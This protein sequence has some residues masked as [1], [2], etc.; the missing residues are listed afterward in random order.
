MCSQAVPAGVGEW[1]KAKTGGRQVRKGRSVAS[2][3]D[4]G[5]RLKRVFSYRPSGD[6]GRT[7]LKEQ[8]VSLAGVA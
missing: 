6:T 4:G 2:V 3:G 8:R 7:D 5:R 1:D